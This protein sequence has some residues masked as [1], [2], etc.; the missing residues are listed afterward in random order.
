[1]ERSMPRSPLNPLPSRN[2]LQTY[3]ENTLPDSQV[4]EARL[5][6][7]HQPLLLLHTNRIMAA[8]AFSNGDSRTSY[9]ALYEKFKTHYAEQQGQWDKL[10]LTF[11]FC[12]PPTLPNL[13][14]FCSSIE[15]D[16]YFCRKFV[17]PLAEPL[18]NSLARLPFLPL[19]PLEGGSLRPPSAQTFLRHCGIPA[20]LARY[21]VVQHERGPERIVEDC[22][23]GEFAE[24]RKLLPSPTVRIRQSDE[25]LDRVR[26][27]EVTIQNFRAYRKPRSFSIGTDVTVLY[28][29]NGF[30]K[31]SF[32]DA[33]DFAVTGGIGRLGASD[34]ARFVK[35]AQHLDSGSE[36]GLVS[37]L[38]TRNEA[39]RK[40]TRSVRDR[41]QALLNDVR[42]DRKA[43]LAELTSNPS[44]ERVEERVDNLISLFRATHLFGQEQQ[45]LMRDFQDDCQLSENI[46]SRM[47]AVEDY[48]NAV[49]KTAKVLE[50]VQSALENASLEIKELSKQIVDENKELS[51]LGQ[52]AKAHANVGALDA[53]L[54]GLRRKVLATGVAATLQKPDIP[55]LRGWRATIEARRAESQSRADR[56][57][58]L[59]REIT[60]LPQ[61]RAEIA[62]LQGLITQKEEAFAANERKRSSAELAVQQMEQRIAENNSK[63][64]GAQVR[65]DL[66][67][68]IRATKPIY[69]QLIEGQRALNSE[70][71]QAADALSEFRRKEEEAAS[72]LRAQEHLVSQSTA[73]LHTSQ[74]ELASLQNLSESI[75]TWRVNRTRLTSIIESEQHAVEQFELLRAEEHELLPQLASAVAEEGRI[76]RQ[77]AEVDKN[78]SDL[79]RLLSQ[80]QGHIR[81]GTCPLCG[82]DHKSKD[83]LVQRIQKHILTDA[84]SL[85]RA[86]LIGV[87]A[88][89]KQLTEQVAANKQKQQVTNTQL[90]NL[91]TERSSL[92]T[93]INQFEHSAANIGMLISESAL[94]TAEQLRMKL[95]LIQGQVDEHNRQV[96]E[97][98]AG[99]EVM[100][101][102]LSTARS[103][104]KTKADEITTKKTA[105][106]RL[107]AEASQ[108]RDDPRLPPLTLDTPDDELDN[109]EGL[110]RQH[111]AGF[112]AEIATLQVEVEQRK[113]PLSALR[114][115][116]AVLKAE[117]PALRSQLANLQRTV[118]QL[119]ARVE[120]ARL[121]ADI[122]EERM[123]GLIADES[124]VQAEMLTLRDSASNLEIAIDAATTAAALTRLR[125]SIRS[126]EAAVAAAVHRHD[127]HIPW[128]K[129]FE[130]LAHLVSSQQHKTISNFTREYGPRASVIQRR[131]RSVYGF[132]DIE[133]HSRKSTIS[134]RVKRHGEELRPIDYFSQSQQQT[135][136]LGLFL[137]ACISQT[138]SAFSPVFLD[139]PVTHFDNLNTYAFLDLIVG[140]LETENRQFI[141]S[142]CDE[143]LFQLARQKFRHLG[144]RAQFYR[145]EA[146]S[147]DGPIITEVHSYSGHT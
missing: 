4:T 139:D 40:L 101:T 80:I 27:K 5:D 143:K 79:K 26:L 137:T 93:A 84:A 29:P 9:Y 71:L 107:R 133:I 113:P 22:L 108:F 105:L 82:D 131:L 78:Q 95:S 59:L 77:I 31:T 140:L 53:E 142:T 86:D 116:A 60:G 118:T 67:E 70:L 119:L 21:L 28:G 12:V 13:D 45:E 136:L 114:Q 18:V 36:E 37:L 111:L 73:A 62:K 34:D 51:Q 46:V 38:F 7:E 66:L 19:T 120:E 10:D 110:N 122:S 69:V 132:D 115:E 85:A 141:I 81:T 47:L 24:P 106:G 97:R 1:M 91:K 96:Q 75:E 121:P 100:Q 76:S 56:L 61:T 64:A 39:T 135:L 50:I 146:I 117:L 48:A 30:G 130:E 144:E 126:K 8:F 147:S 104:L 88:R 112:K 127:Q 6:T 55:T 41:K 25:A 129:Y 94:T 58:T 20:V 44:I 89:A 32:F 134:V 90:S 65:L 14:Q 72:D 128:L 124:H 3:L 87:K 138:W 123:H 23:G 83:Q 98:R 57:S 125:E 43:V 103:L 35:T 16:V 74:T 99:V 42:I 11:V 54:E 102:R 68:W 92:G 145:F 109:L 52:T 49:N 15:T 63:C 33:I 2:S 17:V